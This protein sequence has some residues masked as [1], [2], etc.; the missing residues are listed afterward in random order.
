[1]N[2]TKGKIAEI[3]VKGEKVDVT[4][5][6]HLIGILFA[7]YALSPDADKLWAEKMRTFLYDCGMCWIPKLLA[8]DTLLAKRA[9]R[10]S[11]DFLI[12]VDWMFPYCRLKESYYNGIT[13]MEFS[14]YKRCCNS[15][16][17]NN[18]LTVETKAALCWA[19]V[20][21][22]EVAWDSQGKYIFY[23]KHDDDYRKRI[24]IS[25]YIEPQG[26]RLV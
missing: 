20:N 6:L 8:L 4:K 25:R 19:F 24:A 17:G 15:I 9:Q 16:I 10:R 14:D 11:H 23:E 2:I 5:A 18:T 3:A 13:F 12:I 26:F 7:K 21:L 1:M 22:A